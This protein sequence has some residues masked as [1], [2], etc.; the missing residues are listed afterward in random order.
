MFGHSG[1]T[2]EHTYMYRHDFF[3]M[4]HPSLPDR[5]KIW[6][7]LVNPFTQILIKSDPPHIDFSVDGRMVRERKMVTMESL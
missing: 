6:R 2:A 3:C 7:T 1:H 5:V 4:R